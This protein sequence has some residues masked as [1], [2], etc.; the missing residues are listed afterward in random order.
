VDAVRK[1][2]KKKYDDPEFRKRK[3]ALMKERRDRVKLEK[4]TQQ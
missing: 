3:L 1:I 4:L 2:A